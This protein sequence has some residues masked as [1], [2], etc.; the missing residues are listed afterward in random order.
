MVGYCRFRPLLSDLILLSRQRRAASAIE[1]KAF[2]DCSHGRV[3]RVEDLHYQR[4]LSNFEHTIQA[5]HDIL[6]SYYKV[7]RKRFVD[8]IC[9]QAAGYHLISGPDTPMKLF[10]PSLV[11]E[12]S[13]EQL[14]EIAGEEPRQQRI[15]QQLE[16]EIRGLQTAKMILR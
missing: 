3:V 11:S 1:G 13:V 2:D 5:L 8:N 7:A 16:K 15:R 4:H 12:L 9:M 10:S 14:K 6:Q